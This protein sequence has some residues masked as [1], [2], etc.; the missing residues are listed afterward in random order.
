MNQIQTIDGCNI[1][2]IDPDVKIYLNSTT[3]L[4]RRSKITIQVVNHY[5]T[6]IIFG[7]KLF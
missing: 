3:K 7:L 2:I 4:F 5:L 1:V 6:L